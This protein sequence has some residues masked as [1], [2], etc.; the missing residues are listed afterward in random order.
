MLRTSTARI[1]VDSVS[2]SDIDIPLECR[3]SYK[4]ITIYM[5]LKCSVLTIYYSI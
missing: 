2:V 3:C 5:T 1:T 4:V